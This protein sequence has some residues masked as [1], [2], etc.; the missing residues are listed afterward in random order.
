LFDVAPLA[1]PAG[2]SLALKYQ[3]VNDSWFTLEKPNYALL[4]KLSIQAPSSGSTVTLAAGQN[5]LKL[6]SALLASL[7]IVFPPNPWDGMPLKIQSI[8]G[9]TSLTLNGASGQTIFDPVTTLSAG[10]SVE[11]AYSLD[12]TAWFRIG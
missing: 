4:N 3:A 10:Q 6:T 12:N 9:V 7:T 5:A 11:Y 1:I 8:G 2:E